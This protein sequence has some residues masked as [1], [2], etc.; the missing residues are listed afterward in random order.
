MIQGVRNFCSSDANTQTSAAIVT[1]GAA[2]ATTQVK[3]L[4]VLPVADLTSSEDAT[5]Q[6]TDPT[7]ANVRKL[8]AEGHSGSIRGTETGFLKKKN[9]LYRRIVYPSEDSRLQFVVPM[10]YREAVFKLGHCSTLGGHMGIK[11]TLDR[12]QAHFFW[13]GMGLEV[14]RMLRSCDVCQ[15]TSVEA[16]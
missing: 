13:P 3:P 1:R 6:A 5:E 10:K 4:Q 9:C 8:T 14:K 12:I 16:D 2:K 11:K 7:L 15:K